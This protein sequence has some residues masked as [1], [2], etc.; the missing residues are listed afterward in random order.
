MSIAA[1][2]RALSEMVDRDAFR[3]SLNEMSESYA[4]MDSFI[5]NLESDLRAIQTYERDLEAQEQM[6]FDVGSSRATLSFQR[7]QLD[8]DLGFFQGMKILYLRR[9]YSD[10]YEFASGIAL[11]A[12]T[13]EPRQDG[14][15]PD[16]LANTKM[17]AARPF[18]S[19]VEYTMQDAFSILGLCENLL[20][21]LSSDIAAFTPKIAEAEARAARGFQVG[22]LISNMR[23]QQTR[24]RTEFEASITQIRE[25]LAGNARFA[26]RCLRRIQM[27]SNEIVTQQ[28][29]DGAMGA[30][31]ATGDATDATDAT[32]AAGSE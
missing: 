3:T 27:I 4:N 13:I 24:L 20:L 7:S 12:A 28:E 32:G 9:M 21:E 19:G 31:G 30:T 25:F 5:N 10:L 18:D 26:S 2:D 8:T 1:E 14:Q 6:G 17:A 22:S 11:N 16:E 15:T 23:S 29:A